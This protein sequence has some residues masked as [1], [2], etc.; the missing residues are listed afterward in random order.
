MYVGSNLC[1]MASSS[2]ATNVE[3]SHRQTVHGRAGGALPSPE[4]PTWRHGAIGWHRRPRRLAH[5]L[6]THSHGARVSR[7]SAH[8]GV[9]ACALWTTEYEPPGR[10]T[11]RRTGCTRAAA[12]NEWHAMP[13]THLRT[14]RA[15]RA[16]RAGRLSWASP[17]GDERPCQRGSRAQ[18][19]TRCRDERRREVTVTESA[20][21]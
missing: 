21:S 1:R 17:A 13:S 12:G 11:R 2:Y 7:A 5:A 14:A 15:E 9:A 8:G 4:L 3:S 16:Q 19:A 20:D 6:A 10:R 18:S